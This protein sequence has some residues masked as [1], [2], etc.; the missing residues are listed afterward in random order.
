MLHLRDHQRSIGF[1]V[2][3]AIGDVDAGVAEQCSNSRL[4]MPP[5]ARS[6]A[7]F[8]VGRRVRAGRMLQPKTRSAS[9]G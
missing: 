5:K 6:T 1:G 9:T 7:C 3:A 4:R 8:S 2:R